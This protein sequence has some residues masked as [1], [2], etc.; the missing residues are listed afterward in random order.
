MY[1]VH[2]FN[3]GFTLNS[4]TPITA[5]I[6]CSRYVTNIMLP[7]VLIATITHFTTYYCFLFVLFGRCAVQKHCESNGSVWWFNQKQID[8]RFQEKHWYF[9]QKMPKL[10]KNRSKNKNTQ[11][12][13]W[14]SGFTMV[15]YIL[16]FF[17]PFFFHGSFVTH[18]VYPFHNH[19]F[20]FVCMLKK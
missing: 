15:F 6:N 11:F 5:N 16:R 14:R 8:K 12:W 19:G 20:F 2:G 18:S 4:C 13:W 17:K 10:K 1:G 7:I 9:S 3:N